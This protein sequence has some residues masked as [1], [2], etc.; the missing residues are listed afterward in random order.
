MARIKNKNQD[1]YQRETI[2][3]KFVFFF[4]IVKAKDSIG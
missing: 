4:K 1:S 3:E 2:P